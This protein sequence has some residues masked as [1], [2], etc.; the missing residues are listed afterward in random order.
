MNLTGLLDQEALAALGL[1]ADP[2]LS[3]APAEA[4]AFIAGLELPP[5][6]TARIRAA[7]W[8]AALR[9]QLD[10]LADT[11]PAGCASRAAACSPT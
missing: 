2:V 4:S 10:N 6:R 9:Q 3:L 7:V 11:I 1:E 8:D 5:A